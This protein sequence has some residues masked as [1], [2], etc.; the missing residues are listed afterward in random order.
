M[1]FL[2]YCDVSITMFVVFNI[3]V[4]LYVRTCSLIIVYLNLIDTVLPVKTPDEGDHS[5][6]LK[7]RWV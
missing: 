7:H 5:S 2:S 6:S 4:V 3:Y 1:Y